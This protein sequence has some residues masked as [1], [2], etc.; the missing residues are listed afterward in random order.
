MRIHILGIGGTFM[1]GLAVIAKQMGHEVSGCDENIYPPMST[2]L[3]ELDI[4][5]K[6][7]YREEHL[8]P[9]PDCI[10]VGNVMK[11]G[12]PIIEYML[13]NKLPY[14]SG[15]QWLAENLLIRKWVLAVSG[16]HGKT[17]TSSILT[18]ILEYVGMNPGFLIGGMPNNFSVSAR[19]GKSDFFVIEA[20]EYDCAFFDKRSKFVHYHPQT[21]IVNNLEFDHADIFPDIKAIQQQFHH[22]IRTVPGNGLIIYP[23]HE[24][25]I[26][27]VLKQG[28]W[29][30]TVEFANDNAAWTI[31]E[32]NRDFSEFNI[33]HN[34]NILGRIH[35]ALY[36]RHNAN[37]ALAAILA[38]Q[39]VGVSLQQSIA[40]LT[41][42]TNVKRR[43]EVKGK[44]NK[45]TVYDD[46]AH[47]PTA[48]TAT[49]ASLRGHV[50]NSRIIVILELS[51]NTMRQG[52]FKDQLPIALSTADLVFIHRPKDENWGLDAIAAKIKKPNEVHNEIDSIVNAVA[53]IATSGDHILIMCKTAFGGIHDKLLKALEKGL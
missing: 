47:H 34:G 36:G 50:G 7:G 18:W 25:A 45:I 31:S 8:Q 32:E 20:D 33:C 14:V 52:V 23:A 1:A 30:P 4:P 12:M 35:W 46:F 41:T 17:T 6:L 42:F 37:N 5:V 49:I 21:L 11:R 19:L 39:H 3:A 26:T 22:L 43:L 24:A 10:V 28:C 48:I 13:N 51:S 40:A 27:D 29:T 38:A 16:T 2:Q 53:K 44:C 9:A 15:P